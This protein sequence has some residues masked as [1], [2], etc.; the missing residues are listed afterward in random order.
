[1]NFGQI[2]DFE[3][4]YYWDVNKPSSELYFKFGKMGIFMIDC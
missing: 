1:L 3:Y 4:Q 2:L